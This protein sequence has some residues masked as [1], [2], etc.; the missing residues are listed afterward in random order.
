MMKKILSL[1]LLLALAA[2]PTAAQTQAA[3]LHMVVLGSSTA[4][5]TGPRDP[6]NAWVNRYRAFLQSRNPANVVTNLARGGYTTYHILPDGTTPPPGRPAPDHER[7]INKALSLKP[8]AIIINLPSNDAA[9]G[10]PVKEQL[11]NYEA[12]LAK[13]RAATVPVWITTTQPRNLPATQR[14]LLIAMR[15][16]TRARWREQVIDFW[17]GLA[18]VDGTIVPAYD[19]GDGVHLNDAAHGILYDRVV[20]AGVHN[21]SALTDSLFLDLVQRACFDYFWQE[22]NP[23]N[24]LIK[25][26]SATYA[27]CSIAAVGFGLTAITIAIDRGWISRTAGRDRVL[28]TLNTFWQKPQGREAQ[29]R[30]GYKGFFYHFLDMTTALRTWDSE[31]S[32]IDTALLLAGILDMKQYFTGSDAAETQI[33]SLADSIYYRVDWN[34]MRNFQPNLTGGWSPERGFIGWW[35]SGYNEA[36]IMNLLGLGSPT[37]ALPASIWK[38]WTGGYRWQ[39]LYGYEF[40]SFPPLF[41]HQYSH[42]WIDFRGIQDEYMRARGSDYF[43]NSRRAT[44][45]QRAYCIANPGG[46]LG[47]GENVWGITACDGPNGYKARGAPPPENEDGTIAPTAAGSSMPFTPRE[48]LA[49]LRH[50]YDYYGPSLWTRYGFRDAFNLTRNWWAPNIIGIDQGPM[51]VMIE[52]YRSGRVWRRFMQNPDIQRG[53]QRAG[54]MPVTGVVAKNFQP[55][56]A[57]TLFQNYPNPFNPITN[58]R[59]SLAQPMPVKLRVFDLAGRVVATLFQGTL[60]AGSHEFVF[61]GRHLAGGIYFYELQAGAFQQ[62]GKVLLLK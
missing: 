39:L 6:N 57:F 41:G 13:A 42:C 17:S 49:A 14:Q 56:A 58:I 9:S 29:G 3:G 46:W 47:Y 60:A 27:P 28:T 32:S 50:F 35:W 36:M 22:A 4:E 10:Y 1:C 26:H 25:D 8:S 55:P 51:I 5:G 33:R 62:I 20:A 52:N 44:L 54:F 31:L 15:D 45:A 59:L 12:V 48:S 21:V 43:E 37:H 30:I 19:S 7:N 24:G 2:V 18:N 11:A 23:S 61:D 40:V 34:W 38:A 53:L 16:S